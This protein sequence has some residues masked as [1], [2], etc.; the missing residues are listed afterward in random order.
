MGI[1]REYTG[2]FSVEQ[3]YIKNIS[4]TI[5]SE[6]SEIKNIVN[7]VQVDQIWDSMGSDAIISEANRIIGL[8]DDVRSTSIDEANKIFNGIDTLL[9]VYDK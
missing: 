4:D 9:A 6:L 2:E 7:N 5:E 1:V 3:T 8:L